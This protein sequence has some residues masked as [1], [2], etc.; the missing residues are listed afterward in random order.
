MEIW[1]YKVLLSYRLNDT[2]FFGVILMNF[3]A[4][5]WWL[6][7]LI[8]SGA[9]AI[10]SFFLKRTINEADRHDKEI[11][12]IQL[13]YVTKDE[14]KDVKT[15]VNKSIGKLQTDVEQIKDTCLT[16]KDYYN[17][18]NEVKDEI[19]TQN[20][21]DAEAKEFLQK[22]KAKNFVTNN[23]Q[24]LRTINILHVN[25]EKLSDVKYAM[26]NVPEHD[27][28]SSVNYLFLSE[29]ILLRHIK[30]KEPADIADVPY[31]QLEA[32]LSS[33]GIKLL[34]GTIT[35]NSVEV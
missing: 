25:Y 19:K 33:K 18:I 26:G 6:F 28:L 15:D 22:I 5:T 11:K 10:I 16:K 4:D 14:L 27:F 30:T 31:E 12:E 1:F 8:I 34:D 7:G 3:A 9:I 35:D 21:H 2:L 20:K 23:G 17:S 32:K 13:S 29:Y 24:I